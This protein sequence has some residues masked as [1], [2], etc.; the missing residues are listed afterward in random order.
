MVQATILMQM[1]SVV[2]APFWGEGRHLSP[3]SLAVDIAVASVWN[4]WCNP[5]AVNL[6]KAALPPPA[7]GHNTCPKPNNLA[8]HK[9]VWAHPTGLQKVKGL[10][11]GG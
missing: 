7:S 6:R 4:V 5:Q 11:E 8:T 10:C 2:R 9:A 1:S 3:P